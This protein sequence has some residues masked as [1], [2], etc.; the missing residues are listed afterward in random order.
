[1]KLSLFLSLDLALYS[2]ID[3]LRDG[4]SFHLIDCH[5]AIGA[6]QSVVTIDNSFLWRLIKQIMIR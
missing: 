1:M 6:Q 3:I 2:G 5:D 4:I